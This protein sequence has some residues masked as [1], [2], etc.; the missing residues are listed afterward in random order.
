MLLAEVEALVARMAAILVLMTVI[1]DLRKSYVV[2]AAPTFPRQLVNQTGIFSPDL[3][4]PGKF[5]ARK[6][7]SHGIV[8]IIFYNTL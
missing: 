5:E 6:S 2:F 8:A 1:D 4:A 7:T 3:R